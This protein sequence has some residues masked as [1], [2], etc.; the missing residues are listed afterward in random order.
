MREVSVAGVADIRAPEKDRRTASRIVQA[1]VLIAVFIVV[2]PLLYFV[3]YIHNGIL[4]G[5]REVNF[6]A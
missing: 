3:V 1:V 6:G 2:Y 4:I 5:G